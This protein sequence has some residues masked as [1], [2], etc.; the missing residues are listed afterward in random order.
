[1][2]FLSYFYLFAQNERHRCQAEKVKKLGATY[3]IQEA[4]GGDLNPDLGS[5][6][7]RPGFLLLVFFY[8]FPG[9]VSLSN[10]ASHVKEQKSEPWVLLPPSLSF[11]QPLLWP[12][13]EARASFQTW[14]CDSQ[15]RGLQ[16]ASLCLSVSQQCLLCCGT[17]VILLMF[18][19]YSC[20]RKQSVLP[21]GP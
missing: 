12:G 2:S 19:H 5:K 11:P 14:G 21:G 13:L 17:R 6:N 10:R 8:F 3:F 16:P 18:S 15:M 9:S 7:K 20:R 1:M 4:N